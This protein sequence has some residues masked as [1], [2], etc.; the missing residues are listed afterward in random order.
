M[1]YKC[2][3]KASGGKKIPVNFGTG[4][5]NPVAKH[6]VVTIADTSGVEAGCV[7]VDDQLSEAVSR[8]QITG[9]VVSQLFTMLDV[10]MENPTKPV[11]LS[12]SIQIIDKETLLAQ[13]RQEAEFAATRTM[14][15][16]MQNALLQQVTDVEHELEILRKTAGAVTTGVDTYSSLDKKRADT[17]QRL[18]DWDDSKNR[19]ENQITNEVQLAIS[20]S[21]D[22]IN[23]LKAQQDA[24]SSK[25]KAHQAAWLSI[26]VAHRAAQ[27]TKI[28]ELEDM[29]RIAKEAEG[30]E[31]VVDDIM[32]STSVPEVTALQ[33]ALAAAQDLVTTQKEAMMAAELRY[34]AMEARLASLLAPAPI[35]TG[36]DTLGNAVDSG[37]GTRNP[38]AQPAVTGSEVLSSSDKGKGKGKDQ[39]NANY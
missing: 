29:C 19:K 26:N 14:S 5:R 32:G 21:D 2:G 1:C 37:T 39:C 12:L 23:A 17:V 7:G 22:A 6:M 8:M 33:Q 31:T 36:A 18:R 11:P 24:L 10:P 15:T 4:T 35:V 27:C 16:F 30:I 25:L 28:L 38:E 13:A 3:A 34:Q 20:A 9:P